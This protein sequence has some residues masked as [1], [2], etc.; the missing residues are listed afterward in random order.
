MTGGLPVLDFLRSQCFT[1]HILVTAEFSFAIIQNGLQFA[2]ARGPVILNGRK[3]EA[4]ERNG[5]VY[6]NPDE[7]IPVRNPT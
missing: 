3:C 1:S 2:F 7:E 5:L 6:A 4:R